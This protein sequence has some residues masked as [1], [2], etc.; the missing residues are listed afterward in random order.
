MSVA[1]THF[2][3]RAGDHNDRAMQ[4][5]A[6][7]A[8]I[9]EVR[10]GV[11][12]EKIGTPL[13]ADPSGWR[14][15]LNVALP[16]LRQMSARF[17]RVLTDLDAP[18][19]AL[20]RCSVALATLPI[21]AKHRPDA[22]VVWFDAHADLN[23]PATSPTGYL[24]GLALSGALG[25]WESGLGDGLDSE[26]TIL[27]GTRDFDETEQQLVS[28][29]TIDHV[30]VGGAMA[31]EL[32]RLVDGRPVYVHIDCDV[33]EPGIVPTDYRVP[34]GM[35]LAHLTACARALAQSDVVGLEVGE[36]ETAEDALASS[37]PHGPARTI[38]GALEPLM[39]ALM[40]TASRT[41]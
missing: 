40:Q 16:A 29:G 2:G 4:A 36:L 13:P 30:A 14:D 3:S 9:L 28:K 26:N 6:L 37:D 5:S 22:V 24:G 27:V 39:H 25:L 17:E 21:V 7:L 38:V 18:V 41:A 33:L 23:T 11:R 31:D 19:T 12:A 8:D 34:G 10:L 15:E 35:T 32:R 1:L 20:S